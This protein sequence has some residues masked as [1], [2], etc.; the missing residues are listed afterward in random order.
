MYDSFSNFHPI[1]NFIYFLAVLI[2]SMFFMH[3][4]FQIIALISAITYSIMI[5]GL[6]KGMRFNIIYMMPMLLF[7]AILNPLFN[8][9]GV[10]IF[11]I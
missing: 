6:R 11:F 1:V 9:E 3:P 4:I 7:M 2:F 10:T 5:K 8:H